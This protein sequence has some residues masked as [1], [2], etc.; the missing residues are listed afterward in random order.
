MVRIEDIAD[1]IEKYQPD[2]DI[3]MLRRAYVFSAK[4]HKGQ[5]RASGEPYLTHPLAV[6][7]ILAD[8]RMDVAT[9]CT[10]L[11][12]DVIEDTL[13]TIED[14]D[15]Y[16]GSEIAQLVDG[17]TKISNL[18][19]VSKEE[20]EAESF[21]KL[22]LATVDDVRVM[23][24]KLADRLHNMRTLA[25]LKS[26][27]RKKFAGET[28]D[29]YAPIANRL[30]MGRIR[31]ELEDLAF[32]YLEPEVY[33]DLSKALEDKRLELEEYL[34]SLK[35]QI[36][37]YLTEG[38]V[39]YLR[40]EGRIKHICGV[41]KK[42]LKYKIPL[43]K[44]H[45]LVAV[46]IITEEVRDCYQILG[47][48]HQYWTPVEK[49]FFD[50]IARPLENNYQSLHTSVIGE[51][52][53][54][55]EVQIRT[56]EMHR[57]AEDG[58]AAYWKYKE[59]KRRKT[60]DDEAMALLRRSI[61]DLKD[62][63]DA[64]DFMASFKVNL[65]PKEIY[66]FT[67]KG[68]LIQLPRNATPV[69]FAYAVHTELGDQCTGAKV[70][71]RLVSLKYKIENGDVVEIIRTPGHKPTRDWLNF[72]V[73]SKAR[74]KIKQWVAEKQRAE[75][76]EIGRKMFEREALRLRL[77]TKTVLEDPLLQKFL[78]DNGIAKV[79]D[80][81]AAIGYGKL[82]AKT[83]LVRFVP[84]E[85]L[86]D[87]EQAKTSGFQKVTKV[88]KRALRLGDDRISIK[89]NIDGVMLYRAPCCNPIR[90]EAIIGYIT[91][92][93]GVGVHA[94]RC[95]NAENLLV[96]RER[97]IEVNWEGK[98]DPYPVKLVVITEDRTGQ[99]AALTNKI[100]DI[101]TNIRNVSTDDDSLND[102]TRK[103]DLTVDVTDVD[104]LERVI[105]ALKGINGVIEV[106]RHNPSPHGN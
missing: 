13:V 65:Y 96:N 9:I 11:L 29:V 41:Y 99:L 57:V 4:E 71:E 24:V 97:V 79:E 92:G 74:S 90:G 59:G 88:V 85:K 2:A 55:F 18:G 43:A 47:I 46:R 35:A 100:A 61:D 27:K 32:K 69:D 67:P 39:S 66:A 7:D 106:E 53:Q 12:H 58:V 77:K 83:V 44:V 19:K 86:E 1:K 95:K 102:G 98:G 36:A 33:N 81:F 34:D 54:Y 73:T 48:I 3:D 15:K 52:G 8:L 26:E 76:V 20:V 72:V 80:M 87:L 70:N 56:E 45:D 5:I 51:K 101:K 104:H 37:F 82:T 50:R 14:I 25:H 17:V 91:L 16:F 93:K 103:I 68:K 49:R 94:K 64:R 40:I 21:R 10:G 28:L 75:S 63:S 105:G 60:N 22:I 84:A 62:V 78:T 23:F 89:G 6:A 31:V 42:M 38:D 30:G